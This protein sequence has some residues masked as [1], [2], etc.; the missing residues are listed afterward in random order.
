MSNLTISDQNNTVT[1]GEGEGE[2]I[3]IKQNFGYFLNTLSET[4]HDFIALEVNTMVVSKITGA[5]FNPI[6]A[7]SLIYKIKH[8]PGELD[9]Y[10]EELR[11]RYLSLWDQLVGAYRLCSLDE[12]EQERLP[13]PFSSDP[14]EK[15]YLQRFIN[16]GNIVRT[17]RK[18]SELRA[19][20]DGGDPTSE[21]ID[22]IYAQTIMQL[23]GDVINRYNQALFSSEQRDFIVSLH[24]EGV[25]AGER[26][27]RGLINF[28]VG[29]L[30][31]FTG[32]N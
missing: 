32:S 22:I 15:A 4:L 9:K 23:D 20:L 2:N 6:D 17:L 11:P 18:L 19:A 13:N 7:Y 12:K 29:L 26:Q 31:G 30:K 27:W 8:H 16:M 10:P 28:M 24:K 3:Q 25:E 5:K 21:K 14:A 1:S